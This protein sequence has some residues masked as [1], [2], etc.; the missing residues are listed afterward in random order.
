METLQERCHAVTA[1]AKCG[2]ISSF[3]GRAGFVVPVADIDRGG[4]GDVD[5]VPRV[6]ADVL[7]AFETCPVRR[8][9]QF[10]RVGVCIT[11]GDEPRLWDIEVLAGDSVGGLFTSALR[12]THGLT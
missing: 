9:Q 7:V 8:K 11:A 6:R 12:A 3:D 1:L 10:V 4:L 5:G 2:L